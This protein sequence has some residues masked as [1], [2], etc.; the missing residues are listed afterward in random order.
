MSENK[1]LENLTSEK[2][3]NKIEA[4]IEFASTKIKEVKTELKKKIVGQE[5]LIDCLLI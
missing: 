2:I 4:D 1:N 3:E 5:N